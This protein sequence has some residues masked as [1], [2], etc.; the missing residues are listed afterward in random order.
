MFIATIFLYSKCIIDLG[1]YI[2]IS[3]FGSNLRN[4]NLYKL[5]CHNATLNCRINYNI[6]L[7]AFI[8]HLH[9]ISINTHNIVNQFKQA[10]DKSTGRI[11]MPSD[12]YESSGSERDSAFNK[13]FGNSLSY[14][15]DF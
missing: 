2:Q 10:T 5:R 9:L 4:C 14:Y 8:L 6:I 7:I 1:L 15:S 12:I 11:Q 13:V 3:E